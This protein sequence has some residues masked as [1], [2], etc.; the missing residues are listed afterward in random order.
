MS[1]RWPGYGAAGA[2]S[3]AVTLLALPLS[4][5]LELTNI[6]MLYL[7][8]VVGVAMR[9]GR[10]PAALAA[11][12]N[13]AAFDFV[14]VSPQFSFAVSDVQYLVTFIV[15]LGV[16][17]LV[18]QLTAG[19]RFSAGVAAGREQRMRSLFE[20]A[21]ELSAA[22]E[23][24]QV[25][26]IG[27]AAVQQHFGGQAVVLPLDEGD[28]LMLPAKPPE[29]STRAWPTG[30]CATARARAWEPARWPRRAGATCRSPRP[31]A[32]GACWPWR[33]PALAGC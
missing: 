11:L 21:R 25:V 15:M 26:D 4:G 17:L 1:A 12:L 18:G 16:G 7:L 33:L 6:V 28:R 14:F 30:P 24:S 3:V 29:G 19:L 2:A 20:L 5:V 23:A 31:C 13:V 8:G 10:A 9:F 22:L 32:C 27:T